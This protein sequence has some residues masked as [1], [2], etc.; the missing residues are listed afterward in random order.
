MQIHHVG[1]RIREFYRVAALEHLWGMTPK[2]AER[3]LEILRFLDKHGLAATRD[4]FGVSRRTLYRWKATLKAQGDNPAALAAQSSAPKRRRTP[5]TDPRLVSE[6]RRR[7]TLHP[8]KAKF[9]VLLGPWCARHGIALPSVSTIGRILAKAPDKMRHAPSRID[10]RGKAQAS[11]AAPDAQKTQ[12]GQ[13]PSPG[14]AGLLYPRAHSR[15][16]TPLHRHLHQ[17]GLALCL[18][19]GA[20]LQARP[21]HRPRP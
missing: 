14:G 20:T 1:Y 9:L 11:A 16:D 17:P 13:G 10:S 12:A 4:A 18:C 3:R 21:I 2:D 7:H 15:R 5:N 19:R 8:N 6:I